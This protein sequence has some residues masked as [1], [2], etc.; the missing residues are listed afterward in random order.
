[1]GGDSVHVHVAR[2][3]NSKSSADTDVHTVTYTL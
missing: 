1:M 3:H 2:C